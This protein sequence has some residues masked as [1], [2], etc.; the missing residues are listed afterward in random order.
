MGP[1]LRVGTNT[2]ASPDPRIVFAPRWLTIVQSPWTLTRGP[3]DTE[4]LEPAEILAR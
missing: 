3:I 1:L 4:L 2:Y